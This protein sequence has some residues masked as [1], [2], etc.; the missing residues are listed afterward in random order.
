MKKGVLVESSHNS[1][2]EAPG[3][4]R[5]PQGEDM[6]ATS[7]L[8]CVRARALP[9]QRSSRVAAHA[10][11][12]VQSRARLTGPTQQQRLFLA[13]PQV[14]AAGTRRQQ[15]WRGRC[16]ARQKGSG[17]GAGGKDE[18]G[19]SDGSSELNQGGEGEEQQ[20]V[21]GDWRAFRAQLIQ[22]ESRGGGSGLASPEQPSVRDTEW[23]SEQNGLTS[24]VATNNLE[25]LKEQNPKL[26]GEEAWAHECPKPEKGGLVVAAG[27]VGAMNDVRFWQTVIF[28]VKHDEGG[29]WGLVLNRPTQ[30]TMKDVVSFSE[31]ADLFGDAV[32]Y[33]GGPVNQQIVHVLHGHRLEGANEVIPG[34]FLGGLQSATEAVKRGE[35]KAS[36]LRFFAGYAGLDRIPCLRSQTDTER[37]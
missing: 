32:L 28:M 1:G 34:V 15:Q 26:A 14:A 10:G 35:I 2:G 12:S 13:V 19:E 27:E 20:Q 9:P 7:A 37:F 8:Q 11:R 24:R 3:V 4:R 21:L 18:P 36:E 17:G 6:P 29:S 30:Y 5:G 25:L 16:A 22:E 31:V 23:Y 33:N